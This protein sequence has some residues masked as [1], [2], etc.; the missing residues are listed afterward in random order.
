MRGVARPADAYTTPGSEIVRPPGS[1][2]AT[3]PDK[4]VLETVLPAFMR[5]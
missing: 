2:S 3:P 1:H 5:P 4:M